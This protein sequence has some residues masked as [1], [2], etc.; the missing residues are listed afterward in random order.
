[1]ISSIQFMLAGGISSS[2]CDPAAAFY[3]ITGRLTIPDL[4]TMS[5]ADRAS[6]NSNMRTNVNKSALILHSQL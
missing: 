2:N 3:A 5:S 4:P 1:M 6:S